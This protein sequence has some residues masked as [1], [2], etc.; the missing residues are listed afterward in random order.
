MLGLL[1]ILFST[2]A[3]SVGINEFHLFLRNE[4]KHIAGNAAR[5]Y[6]VLSVEGVAL[7]KRLS[8]QIEGRLQAEGLRRLS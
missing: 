2:G 3:F 7:A 8:E 1:L 5:E 4:L 6:G